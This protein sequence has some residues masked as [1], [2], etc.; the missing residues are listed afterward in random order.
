MSDTFEK[1]ESVRRGYAAVAEQGGG[2]CSGSSCCGAS[3]NEGATQLAARIGYDLDELNALPE[4][5]NMGLSCGNPTALAALKPGEV[6]LDLGS[7]G[8]FDVFIAGRKVGAEGRAIGVDMTPEMLTRARKN[9]V[10]KGVHGFVEFREGLIEA[11]PGG[12]VVLLQH[13]SYYRDR[14]DLTYEERCDL[15]FDHPDSLET[16]LLVEHVQQLS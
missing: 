8:G 6:V 11:L 12:D 3:D 2:C 1:R 7:G 14:A 13:D 15:N 4:G 5:A 9:A 10:D 16:S